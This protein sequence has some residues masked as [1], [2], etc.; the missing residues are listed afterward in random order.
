MSYSKFGC[1]NLMKRMESAAFDISMA[2][3]IDRNSIAV[4]FTVPSGPFNKTVGRLGLEFSDI[5]GPTENRMKNV[6]EALE[7]AFNHG[8]G[9]ML[10]SIQDHKA[11]MADFK[12]I[13]ADESQTTAA[14]ITKIDRIL[15]GF[16]T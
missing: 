14:K 2:P 12:Q 11:A 13:V 4:V 15:R 10:K 3:N 5:D 7:C 1:D 8:Q 16:A 6:A 9:V